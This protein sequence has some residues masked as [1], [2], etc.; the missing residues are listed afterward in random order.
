LIDVMIDQFVN[1]LSNDVQMS[2]LR[3]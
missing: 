2:S 1:R 3:V